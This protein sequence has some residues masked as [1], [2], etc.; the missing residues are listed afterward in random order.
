[1]EFKTWWAFRYGLCCSLL[2]ACYLGSTPFS[3]AADRKLL[4]VDPVIHLPPNSASDV[5]IV[6]I[7]VEGLN[8]QELQSQNE[9]QL[10][11]ETKPPLPG[12]VT[13]S[14]LKSESPGDAA[15][16]WYFTATIDGL[17]ASQTQKRVARFRFE[18]INETAEYALSNQATAAS[19]WTVLPPPDP[20]VMTSWLP[21][22]QCVAVGII[23]GDA[24]ATSL[25][26]Q[27]SALVEQSTKK[28]LGLD[29][30]K[31][32]RD[33]AGAD[34]GNGT[35]DLPPHY[36]GPP[37]YFCVDE[38]FHGHGNFRGAVSLSALEKPETQAVTLD[39]YS[40]SFGA[41][42]LGFFLILVGVVAAWV[43]KVFASNRL[44][45]DQELLPVTMLRGRLE[46]L[47]SDL[48]N[49]QA[50]FRDATPGINQDITQLLQ[51][52]TP[53]YLEDQ[54]FIHP[55][56]PNPFATPIDSS[57]LK[58]FLAERD[59][60]VNL[61]TV[62]VEEGVK[63]A[64]QMALKPARPTDDD[65]VVALGRVNGLRG[66][67]PLPSEAQ[68]RAT[69]TQQILPDLARTV[70]RAAGAAQAT[71]ALAKP[72]SFDRL[73]VEITEL[74]LLVW[75]VAASLTAL[76]GLVVLILNNAGFGICVDYIYCLFWGFGIPTAVQQ[77]TA[78]SASSALGVSVAKS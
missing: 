2:T 12:T 53:A 51:D 69:I 3:A 32:C 38:D 56:T 7:K 35:F 9:P 36:A 28:L 5:G 34:C 58:S 66:Q 45:R 10:K 73:L 26:L 49:L 75:G 25:R 23:P 72:V 41:K 63:P 44:T 39:V 27:Q 74:N 42:L 77:L 13:F 43:T 21:R 15:R 64:V 60:K 6:K 59:T 46:T 8:A 57:G 40:S 19:N 16:L 70:T 52:L 33:S 68:A 48:A 61:L 71:A 55:A 31:L 37:F 67:N 29:H 54:H 18:S 47:Q 17:P 65:I 20:W 24:P 11:D 76:V 4:F 62:L 14:F 1:M 30:L 50:A 78:N 22:T